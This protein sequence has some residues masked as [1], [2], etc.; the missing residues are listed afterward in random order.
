MGSKASLLCCI[1]TTS[2]V[3]TL[4]SS[5]SQVSRDG[6]TT[7][8]TDTETPIS[9]YSIHTHTRMQRSPPQHTST[10][11]LQCPPPSAAPHNAAYSCELVLLGVSHGPAPGDSNAV[12]NPEL[13][14]S[15]QIAQQV[16]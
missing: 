14:P 11:K 15:L 9:A 10:G 3:S 13:A 1:L 2:R 4:H 16:V 5:L 12:G 7:C 6:S 8:H